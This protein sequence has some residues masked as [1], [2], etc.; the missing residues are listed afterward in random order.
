MKNKFECDRAF[1]TSCPEKNHC[2]IRANEWLKGIF[3]ILSKKR[4]PGEGHKMA[5]DFITF[6]NNEFSPRN[7][8][9]DPP[10]YPEEEEKLIP[11]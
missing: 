4:K 11:F 8:N 10:G 3:D 6:M 5:T 9:P 7:R 2:T 1:C